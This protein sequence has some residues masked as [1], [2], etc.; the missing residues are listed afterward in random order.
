MVCLSCLI[1]VIK[2][3]WYLQ[4]VLY[5][6]S[7]RGII[8]I[9]RKGK[10]KEKKIEFIF[11]STSKCLLIYLILFCT[12]VFWILQKRIPC[13]LSCLCYS[14]WILSITVTSV[15]KSEHRK[16]LRPVA[17][18]RFFIINSYRKIL[19]CETGF[20]KINILIKIFWPV[21]IAKEYRVHQKKNQHLKERLYLENILDFLEDYKMC[22][23]LDLCLIWKRKFRAVWYVGHKG[24]SEEIKC[25]QY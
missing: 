9:S 10:P 23:Q 24:A 25:F 20:F 13:V 3:R 21:V 16:Y 2:R 6:E 18:K 7:K 17:V 12:K 5:M 11:S 1:T 4:N 8:R 19:W 14:Y 15:F 22:G